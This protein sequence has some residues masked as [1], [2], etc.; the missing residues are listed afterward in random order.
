MFENEDYDVDLIHILLKLPW[1][2]SV[3]SSEPLSKIKCISIR[4]AS[5]LAESKNEPCLEVFDL[6]LNDEDEEVRSQA[7]ASIPVVVFWSVL[8]VLSQILKRLE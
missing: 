8:R 7:V 4:V 3:I 6:G 1:T 2:H 5:K